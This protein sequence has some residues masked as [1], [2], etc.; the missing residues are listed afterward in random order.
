MGVAVSR[1]GKRSLAALRGSNCS[2]DEGWGD[3]DEA[4]SLALRV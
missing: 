3:A 1:R 2:E 4:S